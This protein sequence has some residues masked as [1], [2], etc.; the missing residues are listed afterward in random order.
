LVRFAPV[1]SADTSLYRELAAGFGQDHPGV[2]VEIV[3]HS[4]SLE[5][6]VA[7]TDCFAAPAS[8]AA[9]TA[10]VRQEILS[11][12]PLLD[13]DADFDLADFYP[14]FLE[15]VQEEGELW[16]LPYEADAMMV[17]IHL[18][19]F[20]EGG[21]ALPQPDWTIQDFLSIAA[22]LSQKEGIYGFTTREGAYGDLLFVLERLGAHL[23]DGSREPPTPTLDDPTVV[24]ALGQYA[25]LA[26][27]VAL[28]PGT[29]SRESGWPDSIFVGDH[30]GGVRAGTV[31]MW[32]DSIR[33]HAAGPALSFATGVQPLPAGTGASTEF[34][35]MAYYISARSPAAQACWAWLTFLSD[36]PEVVDALPAR[37]S[38][39]DATEWQQQVGED[40]LPAYRATLT[41]GEAPLFGLR[42]Q[43][44]WLG[45]AYPWLEEA[46]Q[47]AVA[48]QD[49]ASAL[50]E[51]Q[52][53]A[54]ALVACLQAS[55]TFSDPQRLGDCAR[56]VDPDYP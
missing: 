53:K 25:D 27:G 23:Y 16:G 51:A 24:A 22:H 15:P 12:K 56:Q 10:G 46:F 2:R 29:P 6:L 18:D 14:Q 20:A 3:A 13:A 34:D 19:R 41:Y 39:A 11:L 44:P 35:V 5:E 43:V 32:V 33:N 55:G 7:N 30:P 42:W 40:A 28:T 26:R 49:V 38:I 45:Y 21:V 8:L 17:Y 37:K 36:R 50:A 52:A 1:A 4:T 48:G 47:A 31:A 9:D 54:E